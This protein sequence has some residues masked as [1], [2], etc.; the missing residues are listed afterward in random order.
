MK[1]DGLLP[2]IGELARHVRQGYLQLLHGQLKLLILARRLEA[3]AELAPW[4]LCE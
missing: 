4:H 2:R 1:V 3:L